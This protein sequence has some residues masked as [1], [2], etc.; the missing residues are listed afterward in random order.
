MNTRQAEFESPRCGLA[1]RHAT[2]WARVVYGQRLFILGLIGTL[3]VSVQI[4]GASEC[5]AGSTTTFPSGLPT[6]LDEKEAGGGKEAGGAEKPSF[7]ELVKLNAEQ[8]F[9]GKLSRKKDR[10]TV[11]FGPGEFQ[12]GFDYRGRN[13]IISVPGEVRNES[14]KR[15]L[16]NGA[17][18]KFSFAG[19]GSSKATSKFELVDDF[20]ISFLLRAS[21]LAS[22]SRIVW[23]LNKSGRQGI[24]TNFFTDIR[25]NGRR[26]KRARTSDKRFAGPPSRWFDRESKG[27][28]VHL[29][30]E[31][32]VVTVRVGVPGGGK[33]NQKADLVDV[34]RLEG[35]TAPDSGK[36]GL[37]FDKV[38][39]LV[40]D[41]SISGKFPRAWVEKK[42]AALEKSG[43]L[44]LPEVQKG[45]EGGER[46]NRKRRKKRDK[47]DLDK[48]DPEAD[49][50]L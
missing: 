20:R 17:T 24:Q 49:E 35:V 30:Y 37:A 27:V 19:I 48:P 50:E 8:L 3:V 22:S 42:L 16:L 9:G 2:P 11:S 46:K 33:E 40:S 29:L 7:D 23:T 34:V 28:P 39:F 32:G 13:A 26:A 31:K 38:S 44:R 21:K 18:G 6:A 41:F 45:K 43:K 12:K 47:P 4:S 15:T 25:V 5:R 36:I 10:F 14:L 1:A